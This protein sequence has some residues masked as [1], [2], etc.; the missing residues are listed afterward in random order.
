MI[1]REL[2][3][4]LMAFVDVHAEGWSHDEWLELLHNLKNA[5]FDTS[6]ED[7]IGM[8]LERARLARTL[9]QM[10]IKGLGPKRIEAV[11]DRFGTLW[12]LKHAPPEAVDEI[13]GLPSDVIHHLREGLH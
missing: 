2:A 8:A 13:Q 1:T 12:N 11:A 10:G 7:D 5:G 9:R 3:R 6:K 4:E